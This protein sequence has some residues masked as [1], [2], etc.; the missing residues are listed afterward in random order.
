MT[1]RELQIA[2]LVCR[3]F[4]NREISKA[5]NIKQGTIKTHLRNIYR[6]VRVKTKITLLLKFIEDINIYYSPVKSP[7]SPIPIT[8]ISPKIGDESLKPAHKKTENV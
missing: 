2:I 3:G 7:T 8:E 6:R 5:L 1:P 4:N